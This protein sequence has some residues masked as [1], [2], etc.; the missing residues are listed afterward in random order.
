MLSQ[1]HRRVAYTVLL[2]VFFS[3]LAHYVLHDF[4]ARPGE[5]GPAPH[6]LEPWM[7]R[8]HGAAAM[9]VLVL[10]GTLLPT[11]IG[12][13]WRPAPHSGAGLT[14]LAFVALL[15]LTGYGLYYLG[16]EGW[17]AFCR[18]AHIVGGLVA[19]P[20]FAYHLWRG[21]A[22]RRLMLRSYLDE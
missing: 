18:Q 9:A 2:L 19:V 16:G 20:V 7:L 10:L 3:G 22:L 4:L 12:R 21:R 17:R 8:L 13:F 15:V 11:H 14:F 1:L 5:F 6:P